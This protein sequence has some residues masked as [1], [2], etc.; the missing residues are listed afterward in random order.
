MFAKYLNLSLELINLGYYERVAESAMQYAEKLL[1][2]HSAS[3]PRTPKEI[4]FDLVYKYKDHG[5]VIDKAE[6]AD[7]F[8]ASSIKKNTQEYELGNSLYRAFDFNGSVAGAVSHNFYFIGSL[9][10]KGVFTKR[11]KPA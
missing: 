9:D 3:L 2:T 1:S 6:A 4:A 10:A 8:G 11:N 7:I 5:F